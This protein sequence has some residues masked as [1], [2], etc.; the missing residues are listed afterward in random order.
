M[1]FRIKVMT[2]QDYPA[3]VRLWRTT[4][5]IGLSE[6]DSKRSVA[7]YLKRNRGLSLVARAK[8]GRLVAAVLCGHDGRRGYLYHL[9][10]A[11]EHRLKGLGIEL[12]RRCLTRLAKLGISR[13][14]IFVYADNEEGKRFWEKHGWEQRDDLRMM[15]TWTGGHR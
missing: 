3:A 15:Q 12:V 2:M 5:G 14:N 4:E 7:L 9:V 13:C 8:D 1:E 6:S 10:V 11:K